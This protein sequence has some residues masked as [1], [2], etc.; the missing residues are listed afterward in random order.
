VPIGWVGD[1]FSNSGFAGAWFKRVTIGGTSPANAPFFADSSGNV[2]ANGIYVNSA[3]VPLGWIGSNGTST[4]AWFMKVGIGA[5]SGGNLS[6]CPIYADASGNLTIQGNGSGGGSV[7]IVNSAFTF[8]DA[9]GDSITINNAG[10]FFID[11]GSTKMQL[12]SA[13]LVQTDSGGTQRFQLQYNGTDLQLNLLNDSAVVEAQLL[14]T[15]AGGGASGIFAKT[16]YYIGLAK[17]VDST[18][19]IYFNN[20]TAATASSGVATLPANPVGFLQVQ[21]GYPGTT[22]K[23]PYYAA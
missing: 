9:S 21:V 17:L 20:P 5:I 15:S 16:A 1:D 12:S 3:G 23:V 2:V 13:A 11:K 22:Y 19:L 14:A 8:T 7:S 6:T 10:G 18:G 4:G